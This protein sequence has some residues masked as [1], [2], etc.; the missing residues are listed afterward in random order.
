MACDEL[1][2]RKKA[3]GFRLKDR[4]FIFPSRESLY[5]LQSFKKV[6]RDK[7]GFILCILSQNVA[8]VIA[9]QFPESGIDNLSQ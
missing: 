3:S 6:N 1:H 5:R 9:V 2:P 8:P 7:L 4:D